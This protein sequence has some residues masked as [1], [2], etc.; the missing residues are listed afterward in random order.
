M[1]VYNWEQCQSGVH[2]GHVQ[3]ANRSVLLRYENRSHTHSGRFV[4]VLA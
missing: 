1:T 3:C 2:K 4:V